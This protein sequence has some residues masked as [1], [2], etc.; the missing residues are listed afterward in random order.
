MYLLY[1]S[2]TNLEVYKNYQKV[3]ETLWNQENLSENLTRLKSTF[4][5]KFRVILSDDF[6]TITSLVFSPKDSLRRSDIQAKFQPLI[7]QDLTKI[8]W[9]YK[10][11]SYLNRQPLVQVVALNTDFFN[12]FRQA[13]AN[14]GIKVSLLESFS[15]S[16]SH[17]LPGKKLI[18][19]HYQDL[20]VL[21]FN[22]TP[23]FSQVLTEKFS[24][25]NIDYF[26]SYSKER[27]NILPQQIL[28]SPPGDI[29]FNQ[30]SFN[31]LSPEYTTINP[32][33]GIAHSPNSHGP[34]STTS[35]LEISSQNK[36]K[37]P[38]IILL[39]PLLLLITALIIFFKFNPKPSQDQVSDSISPPTSTPVPTIS[40][41]N[42]KIQVLN[43]SGTAGQAGIVT[44]LL[45]KNNFKIT[46][47]GNANN[48]DYQ[49]TQVKV[50]ASVPVDIVAQIIK[51]LE[52][53]FNP[54]IL[55]EKLPE[56]SEF[57]I[58]ITTGK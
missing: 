33:R 54:D 34:D 51:S 13:I 25:E 10:I 36:P 17:L 49:Q 52:A 24:Q 55:T 53:D 58:I 56:S 11:V 2:K 9:D 23:V 5:S 57:D 38:K 43:G 44:Q 29:A 37:I 12:I 35:R 47:T 39:I 42:L 26:F 8:V 19:L 14:A 30:F 50:K 40:L 4:S 41:S 3:G 16:L 22:K 7:D 15:T 46:D 18:L 32:L 20:L 1:I 31:D 45:A 48:F 6:T 21:I 28:F 27:F